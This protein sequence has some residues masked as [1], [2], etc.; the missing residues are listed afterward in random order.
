MPLIPS[1]QNRNIR[2]M[3]INVF[4]RWRLLKGAGTGPGRYC[5]RLSR[6]LASAASETRMLPA[7]LLLRG[8]PTPS[9]YLMTLTYAHPTR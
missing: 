8:Q 6:V 7:G 3:R 2:F 5:I 9:G 1:P 4:R